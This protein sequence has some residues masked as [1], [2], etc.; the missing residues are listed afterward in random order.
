MNNPTNTPRRSRPFL[1]LKYFL[2]GASLVSFLCAAL[3]AISI[4][5]DGRALDKAIAGQ[6]TASS[7]SGELVKELNNWVYNN[8]GFAKNKNYFM[9]KSL[10]PTPVQV[11]ESGGDCSDKS[12]LLSA[13]L[14]RQGVDSTLVM[15]Y[16]CEGC[17]PTHT[18]VEARYDKG[19]MA[20]DPVYDVV[21][22]AENGKF[23]GVE[24]LRADPSKLTARLD[25]LEAE[26]T[27]ADKIAAYKRDI[28]SYSW[29]KTINW[30]KN[31]ILQKMAALIE[32]GGTDPF[33][34]MRPYFLED[35]KL[36]LM[37]L[38]LFLGITT[39]A[40]ALILSRTRAGRAR[41]SDS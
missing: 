21:F 33:L 9:F 4:E 20:A 28:E 30:D 38:S 41:R 7:N 14:K 18:V 1:Y 34:V 19:R 36:F 8:K 32:M 40:G 6:I 13:L 25:E 27:L 37:Y 10:G 12:R 29:P 2:S 5:L 22:P 3:L 39:G 31:V 11:L 15:L 17:E 35:P 23:Y 26:R 16:E 24:D